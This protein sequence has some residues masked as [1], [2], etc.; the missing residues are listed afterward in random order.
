MKQLKHRLSR[1][2]QTEVLDS[3]P[4][5]ANEIAYLSG[6]GEFDSEMTEKVKTGTSPPVS[7]CSRS[8]FTVK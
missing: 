1:A 3:S 2:L 5:P 6:V 7:H 8:K 4:A